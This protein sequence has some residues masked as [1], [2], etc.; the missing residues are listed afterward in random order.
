MPDP[1][2]APPALPGWRED[3][4]AA[5]LAAYRRTLHLLGP[6]WPDPP[7]P[8]A[9]ARGFFEAEFVVAA[10]PAPCHFTGYYEPELTGR[11][12]PDARYRHPL[13]AMPDDLP[14]RGPWYT[15]RQIVEGDLLAG[16][17]LVWLESAIEAFLAQVQGS[18]RVRLEDGRLLR[19]GYAGKNGH[20][21][22]SIGLELVRR[23]EIPADAISASWTIATSA[24]STTGS[25]R[26][27]CWKRSVLPIGRPISR[28]CGSSCVPA[29]SRCCR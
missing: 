29:A 12:R 24:A 4:H 18:V 6:D 22:R 25:C 7:R 16:R 11:T 15:R 27:K 5:A 9:D 28:A 21:Y 13:H 19:L 2:E 26:S 1:W 10:D 20:A 23:G 3:D 17:E 14:A 8:S